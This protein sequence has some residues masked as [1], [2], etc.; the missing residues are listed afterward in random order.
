MESTLLGLRGAQSKFKD[1]KNLYG[2]IN[3]QLLMNEHKFITKGDD[4][5]ALV[6]LKIGA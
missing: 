1:I 4:K 3:F 2:Q 5:I 6:G